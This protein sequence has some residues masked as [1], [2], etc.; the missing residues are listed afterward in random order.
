MV[1]LISGWKNM[2]KSFIKCTLSILF[3]SAML[4]VDL[5]HEH[6]D[7]Y[8]ICDINCD[9]DNHHSI[10]HQCE[11]CLKENHRLIIQGSIDGPFNI[12]GS[13]PYSLDECF[14]YSFSNFSLYSRP[15]PSLL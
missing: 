12:S 2:L 7:G 8:N 14:K 1:Y 15:P 13:L 10:S 11:K 6:H 9:N 4:H 5:H 3:L